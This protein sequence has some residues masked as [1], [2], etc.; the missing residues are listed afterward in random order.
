MSEQLTN[1]TCVV[2]CTHVSPDHFARP[3]PTTTPNTPTQSAS[4]ATTR[5]FAQMRTHRALL[6]LLALVCMGAF[7]RLYDLGGQSYWM[8]EGYTINAVL[9][10]SETGKSVL[11]SGLPY[12]CP[13]YCYPTAWLADT[14]GHTATIYRLP[15]A[16]AGILLI[17][18]FYYIGRRLGDELSSPRADASIP[19]THDP[20]HRAR[21]WRGAEPWHHA[22]TWIGLLSAAFIAFAYFQIAWS[23]QARWYT[24]FALFFWIA[25]LA[26]YHAYYYKKQRALTIT[27]AIG[28][29]VLAI[30]THGL[31]YLLPFIMLAWILVDRLF[32]RE[33]IQWRPIALATL[34]IPATAL[35]L[36][37]TLGTARIAR[38]FEEFTVYTV[39]PHYLAYYLTT[40]VV[41]VP[42]AIFGLWRPPTGGRPLLLLLSFTAVSYLVPLMFLTDIIHYRYAWHLTPVLF[43]CAAVGTYR[44]AHLTIA[45]A[46]RI[47]RLWRVGV[48]G[49][50]GV[51]FVTLGTGTLMPRTHY[52][53][54]ADDPTHERRFPGTAGFYAYTPQPDWNDA[55]AYIAQERTEDDLIISSHPHFT[56]IFLGEP[57]YWLAYNYLGHSTLPNTIRDG[58]EYYVGAHV[59][60]D[61]DALRTRMDGASGFIIF[62][63]MALDGRLAPDTVA[64]IQANADFV[65]E[66]YTN[67][68]SQVWVYRFSAEYVEDAPPSK[69]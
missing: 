48:L 62:D 8:D 43:L 26:F 65:Y 15:A 46:D 49:V 12:S 27:V 1:R 29:T 59:L 22:G 16:L 63:Y 4:P 47:Q 37:L 25:L 30:L 33:H 39:A 3:M 20:T 10:I 7:L 36:E 55:Y 69:P 34:A 52:W 35:V 31:G 67:A 44:L 38:L 14:F 53:L 57:G 18:L 24:L 19:S 11:D 51:L 60:A 13:I 61:V 40:Y 21:G 42:L 17:I 66:R 23:R 58:R 28:A 32:L 64:Y 6:I 9:A 5:L 68:Y 56:K 41:L 45:S 50:V 2:L 54:E